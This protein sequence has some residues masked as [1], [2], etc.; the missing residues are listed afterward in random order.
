MATIAEYEAWKAKRHQNGIETE[1][2]TFRTAAGRKITVRKAISITERVKAALFATDIIT[3]DQ[4]DKRR[5]E[6][7]VTFGLQPQRRWHVLSGLDAT[8]SPF[9]CPSKRRKGGRE[10]PIY[11]AFCDGE[12][13]GVVA[14][15]CVDHV[16]PLRIMMGAVRR[17]FRGLGVGGPIVRKIVQH[18]IASAPVVGVVIKL[19]HLKKRT[20]LTRCGFSHWYR[21]SSMY[22]SNCIGFS[23]PVDI[24]NGLWYATPAAEP[25]EKLP[26]RFASL[27]RRRSSEG[28]P[29]IFT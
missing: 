26:R 3:P 18:I 1:M 22:E 23:R 20:F 5:V 11:T 12:L 24:P 29:A 25:D 13:V 10:A 19:D 15:S 28:A 7:A 27:L 6:C 17:D 14:C 21:T 16:L 2:I 4:P 8:P 9:P